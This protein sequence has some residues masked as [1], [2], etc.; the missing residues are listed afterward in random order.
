[1]A[2]EIK[3]KKEEL[4]TFLKDPK[5]YPHKPVKVKLVQTHISY[6]ALASPYVYKI[7]KPVDLGF[8]DFTTLQK[9]EYFCQRE[10]QLNR[11]LCKDVYEGV[12]PISKINGKLI[13]DDETNIVEYA[14]KMNQLDADGFFNK[15]LQED[16]IK[17]QDLDRL[18]KFISH[19]YHGQKSSP[20][21]AE[22]GFI[23]NIKATIE[24][25]FIQTKNFV[26][27]LIEEY[28]FRAIQEF[29][30]QFFCRYTYLLNRRRTEGHILD[31]H[32]DLRL[33]HIHFSR[34]G[35]RIFD[36]IEFN[37]RFRYIDV[38]NEIAFLAM[39]L[40]FRGRR[41]L[42]DY[43]A[44]K[45][46]ESLD[47][48]DL[49]SLLDFYKCYRAYVRAKVHSLK[50]TEKE[51]PKKQKDK[52]RNYAT[53]L[54][55]LALE[56]A[57]SGSGPVVIVIMGRIGTGKSTVAEKL[58]SCLGW[59]VLDSDII[60]KQLAGIPLTSRP[61]KNGREKLYSKEMTEKT[62]NTLLERSIE[63]AK[64]G[65]SSLIDAT[66]GSLKRRSKLRDTLQSNNIRFCFVELTATDEAIKKRLLE[67]GERKNNISDARIEDYDKL[68]SSYGPPNALEL[69]KHIIADNNQ[70]LENTLFNIL[71]NVI[72][73][74]QLKV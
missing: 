63:Y 44:S 48:P 69:T 52:S 11:R 16:K 21:I 53:R 4:I 46:A 22:C 26:G 9:R 30:E 40:D 49:L 6:I 12:V 66:F 43:F 51:V 73:I 5:S 70:P 29:N 13:I 67:R 14:V 65:K 74:K 59:E 8:L 64:Q 32:G 35:I 10:V 68:N 38:A 24:E 31:C 17:L 55:Q 61:D 15:L 18:V 39:D 25:N 34:D 71:K 42:S 41:D 58:S 1:M 47:D 36:C 2:E 23:D 27:S 54:Y 3:I 20:E 28:A 72:Q 37:D 7:K 45:I 60:R 62:Y 56:Y 50:S 33:E 19:F 57:I